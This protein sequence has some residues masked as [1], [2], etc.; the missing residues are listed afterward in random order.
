VDGIWV[1]SVGRDDALLAKT[2]RETWRSPQTFGSL[3]FDIIGANVRNI[4]RA[5]LLW[6]EPR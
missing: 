2:N 4:S 5:D 1:F 3:K 6:D